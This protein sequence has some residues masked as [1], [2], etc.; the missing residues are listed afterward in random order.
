MLEKQKIM[1]GKK[2][3]KPSEESALLCGGKGRRSLL[4]IR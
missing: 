3:F 2:M 1:E 4:S